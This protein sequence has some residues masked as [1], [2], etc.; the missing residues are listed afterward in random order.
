MNQAVMEDLMIHIVNKYDTYTVVWK[1]P[2][3]QDIVR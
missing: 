1:Q 3:M 2:V